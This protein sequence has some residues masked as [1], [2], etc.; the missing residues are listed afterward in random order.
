MLLNAGLSMNDVNTSLPKDPDEALNASPV[1]PVSTTVI[2]LK[3]ARER[4]GLHP[5][6]LAAMLKISVKRLEALEAGRFDELPDMT[7][8][9]ALALSVCRALK[10]D[11]QPILANFPASNEVRLSDIER[12]LNAPL[13]RR[14]VAMPSSAKPSEPSKLS[15]PM[16]AA[17]F[18][19]VVALMLWFFLPTREEPATVSL[20]SPVISADPVSMPEPAVEPVPEEAV[21]EDAPSAPSGMAIEAPGP[22]VPAPASATPVDAQNGFAMTARETAW[23]QVTGASGR[24][25]L[26]RSLQPGETVVLSTDFPLSVVVGR[27][28]E[29]VVS[30]RGTAFN[31][32]PHTRNNVARFE[33]R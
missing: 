25:L 28:D 22:A 9:R 13:P 31:M 33:V 6:A 8:A 19:A 17:V 18:M 4:A 15:W 26:Q 1:L 30:L 11:P 23:V 32:A 21:A 29:V 3:Q 14:T 2:T 7:F 12:S 5:V 10:V 20:L 16:A 27:A 24:V